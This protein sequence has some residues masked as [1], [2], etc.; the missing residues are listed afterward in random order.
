MLDFRFLEEENS[1]SEFPYIVS[2][3]AAISLKSNL[4]WTKHFSELISLTW[5]IAEY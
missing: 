1:H 2:Q 4:N 3:F 5:K